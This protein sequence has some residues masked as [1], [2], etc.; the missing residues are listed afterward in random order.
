MKHKK[1][2]KTGGGDMEALR[3]RCSGCADNARELA[4]ALAPAAQRLV[5][6]PDSSGK[7]RVRESAA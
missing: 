5:Q 2:N 4:G 7:G 6:S 3:E 1:S